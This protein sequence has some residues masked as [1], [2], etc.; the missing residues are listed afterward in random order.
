M[1][2]KIKNDIINEEELNMAEDEAKSSTNEY[3]HKFEK[4]FTY[5][6]KTYEQLAF[7]WSRLSGND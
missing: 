1:S 4:P 5:E 2:E 3:V 7:D 6:D